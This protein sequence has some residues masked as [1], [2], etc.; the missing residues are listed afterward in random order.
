MRQHIGK[1]CSNLKEMLYSIF[2]NEISDVNVINGEYIRGFACGR[3]SAYVTDKLGQERKNMARQFRRDKETAV[4]ETTHGTVHGFELDGIKIFKGIPYAK[5]KRFHRPERYDW[6]GT[7]KATNYGFVCPLLTVDHPTEELLVPHRYWPQDEDCLNLNIWTPGINDDVKR[8]VV[9]WFHGGGYTAG[10]SIEQVAYEGENMAR[11]GDVVVVSVNHRLNILGYFDLSDFGKEYE[12]SGNAGT[13]DLIAALHWI[14]ENAEKFGGD[15]DNV[16]IFGQ[17]GGG[18]KVTCL[19]QSPAADGLYHRAYIMSGVCYGHKK[20]GLSLPDSVGSGKKCAEAVMKELGVESVEELEK[21]PYGQLAEAYL[22][23][24]PGLMAEGENVGCAP[25]PNA[26]YVG[27]PLDA[28]FRKETIHIPI[29]IGTVYGEFNFDEPSYDKRQM[30]KEE[31]ISYLEDYMGKAAAEKLI[32]LFEK[33]YPERAVIDLSRLDFIFRPNVMEYVELRTRQ[34]GSVY[35]YI[36]NHD[37]HVNGIME[38]WHC[39]D[40]PYVFHNTE[41]ALYTQEGDLVTEKLEERIFAAFMTFARTGNPGNAAI[42]AWPAC[43]ADCE[44]TM[45]INN[46]WDVRENFDHELQE[47]GHDDLYTAFYKHTDLG[48]AQH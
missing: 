23:V 47:T 19:L 31:Q 3:F 17:S 27:D 40:I 7:F 6:E 45:V 34:G 48:N 11:Q 1:E 15:P 41:L 20:A 43:T 37:M 24:A 26:F 4:V 16:T 14:H 44:Y 29:M 9:V 25:H 38:P 2:F 30:T 35:S 33:A 28:G 8:P 18:G 12:N 32:P 39:S 46:Q 42:P 10:S 13:D 5:A 21:V 22:K 36:F